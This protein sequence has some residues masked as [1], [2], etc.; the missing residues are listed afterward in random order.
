LLFRQNGFGC[1]FEVFDIACLD[2]D[3]RLVDAGGKP[4]RYKQT[5]ISRNFHKVAEEVTDHPSVS[6]PGQ[7][8]WKPC[9]IFERARGEAA[10]LAQ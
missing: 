2:V 10:S 8:Y 6:A 5:N 7:K 1:D 3:V 4:Y 9:P